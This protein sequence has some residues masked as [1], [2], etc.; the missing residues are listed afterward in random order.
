MDSFKRYFNNGN[1]VKHNPHKQLEQRTCQKLFGYLKS[2]PC[3]KK[4]DVLH[5]IEDTESPALAAEQ[6]Q[7]LY[8]HFLQPN[9][10]RI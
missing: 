3:T 10:V 4:N 6:M 9:K 5:I 1:H 2:L 8:Q 7:E